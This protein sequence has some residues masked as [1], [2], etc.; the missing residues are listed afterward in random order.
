ML[1]TKL[2]YKVLS[3]EERRGCKLAVCSIIF[4]NELMVHKVFVYCGASG[5]YVMYPFQNRNPNKS[6]HNAPTRH[7]FH[8]VNPAFQEYLD[9]VVIEG[10]RHCRDT[11]D[12][13]FYPS[14]SR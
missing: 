13:V 14:D 6:G 2:T 1:A 9:K 12:E 7:M 3:D 11:G 10:Y 5:A 4:D 8:P